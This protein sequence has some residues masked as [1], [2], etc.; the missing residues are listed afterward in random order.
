MGGDYY[1]RDVVASTSSSGY[2]TQ[3]AQAVGTTSSIHSSM[4]PSRW[5]EENL[6]CDMRHPIVFALD[7]TGSMGDWTRVIFFLIFRLF[8]IRC[9]CF[10]ARL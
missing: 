2:S 5:A 3:S 8:M 4:K 10:T 9:P 7:V 1:D 6:Q